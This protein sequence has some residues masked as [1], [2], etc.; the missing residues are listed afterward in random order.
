MMSNYQKRISSPENYPVERKEGYYVL[1]G[2]GPHPESEG[3]PLGVV[4]RDVLDYVD[5][6]DEA[7]E[8]L[9]RGEVLVNGRPRKNPNSTT[10]FMDTVSFPGIGRYFRVL[11]SGKGFV[12][13]DVDEDEAGV[14]LARVDDKTTLKG[15]VT[16]LNLYD[17]NN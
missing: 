9:S 17:G 11:V 4:L 15:G 7:E 1:K 3:V 10:G 12:M 13:K 6:I 8:V 16:Q 2:E 14:K 5:T